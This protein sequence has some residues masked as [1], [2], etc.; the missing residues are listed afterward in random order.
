MI[1]PMDLGPQRFIWVVQSY[2]E[3]YLIRIKVV[4][5]LGECE[6]IELTRGKPHKK[7]IQVV[8]STVSLILLLQALH[9]SIMYKFSSCPILNLLSLHFSDPNYSSTISRMIKMP[10]NLL[11]WMTLNM[12][13]GLFLDPWLILILTFSY[14]ALKMQGNF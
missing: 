2:I 4:S 10:W 6:G 7:I 11:D 13:C 14:R 12:L 1:Q 5:V 3:Y 8:G 9:H